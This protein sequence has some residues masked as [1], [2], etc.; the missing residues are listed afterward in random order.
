MLFG[1]SFDPPHLGHLEIITALCALSDE[2][3]VIPAYQNPFK[4][5]PKA[6]LLQR[7]KWLEAMCASLKNVCISDIE[8]RFNRP[9]YA[10]EWVEAFAKDKALILA[11]GSDTLS[12]LP[13]WKRANDLASLVQIL[14]IARVVDSSKRYTPKSISQNLNS[15]IARN[16][17]LYCKNPES[18]DSSMQEHY[19]S[20]AYATL[21]ENIIRANT[22]GFVCLEPLALLP[23]EIASSTLRTMIQTYHELQDSNTKMCKDLLETIMAQLFPSTAQEVLKIY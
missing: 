11:L 6:S 2:V 12:S 13:K 16:N 3:I 4:Q 15:I 21:Q 10:I 17:D 22:A 19:S 20:I 8:A 14:P 7:I 1:G 9:M 23:K 5:M 18:K